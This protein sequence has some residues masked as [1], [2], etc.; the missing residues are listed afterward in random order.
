M[1]E[2]CA[3]G[4]GSFLPAEMD[5]CLPSRVW[6][7]PPEPR[8]AAPSAVIPH[9]SPPGLH[10]ASLAGSSSVVWPKATWS[11][12]SSLGPSRL[13]DPAVQDQPDVQPLEA[14]PDPVF[15]PGQAAAAA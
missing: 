15:Q 14:F 3:A 1:T 4:P 9:L 8:V 13:L 11:T 10:Q 2:E 5:L 7:P 6:D 12:I